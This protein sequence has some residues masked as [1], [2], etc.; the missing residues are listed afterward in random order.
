VLDPAVEADFKA[1]LSCKGADADLS[2]ETRSKEHSKEQPC[3]DMTFVFWACLQVLD[4]SL[5][6]D[7]S[8]LLSFKGP[9]A[10]LSVEARSNDGSVWLVAY[11]RD[12]AAT[13]YYV[14]DRC[15]PGSLQPCKSSSYVI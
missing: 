14:Y 8:T 9:D 7:F 6:A 13:E 2:L 11:S 4:T 10:D 15:A 5:E 12:N 3:M 1:L